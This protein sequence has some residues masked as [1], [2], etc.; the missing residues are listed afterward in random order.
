MG[1]ER[2]RQILVGGLLVVLG[3]AGYR[4]WRATSS[5]ALPASNGTASRPAAERRAPVAAVEAPDVHLNAL[6]APRP[7]PLDAQ[8][9]LFRFKPKAAPPPPPAPPRL[10][11]APTVVSAPPVPSGPPPP[12]PITLKF[13]GIVEVPGKSVR[14]AVLT[15][16]RGLPFQ[17]K[18]G[19]IIE[20]RYRILKIGTESVE[21]AYLD[22]RGR[23][24]IRLSGG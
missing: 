21:L 12:P 24:T 4:T 9:N 1:A 5:P 22:G 14:Y 11:R 10:E 6:E 7:K 18:E 2:R 13:I 16:G 15:D 19:D 20:G 23:Q 17:G 3:V 8:R